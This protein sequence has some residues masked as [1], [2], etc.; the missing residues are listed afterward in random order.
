MQRFGTSSIGTYEIGRAVLQ[1]DWEAAIDLILTER[2][3]IR[4]DSLEARKIWSQTKNAGEA[5]KL[6]PRRCVAECSI[7][8]TLAK[9][10]HTAWT[11]AF[12]SIPRNLR[13]IY[14]HAYQSL[15]WN[16]VVSERLRVYGMKPVKGDLVLITSQEQAE[17]DA[18]PFDPEAP[19]F[20]TNI[21]PMKEVTR[22]RPLS[23]EELHSYTIY[24]VVLPLPG[25]DIIYPDN[26]IR[27]AYVEIM[28]KDELDPF[29]MRRPIKECSLMGSYRNIVTRAFHV[30]WDILRYN[31]TEKQLVPTDADILE[32]RKPDGIVED[33]QFMAV[34]V[35]LALAQS[36]YATMALR[37]ILK[38]DTSSMSQS[39][40]TAG[41]EDQAEKQK[42]KRE[43]VEAT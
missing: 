37:E 43:M 27:D 41:S 7:L 26:E 12:Q 25:F 16:R 40:L 35:Q 20:S 34:K 3:T 14:L 29:S 38:H 10:G 17:Q 1:V 6:M 4:S 42:R 33:G 2:E 28:K 5:L 23:E 30:D 36:Q 21:Q 19:E 11:T 31:D 8:R 13:L 24:D 32:N 18:D 15:V 39:L 22:A 9:G